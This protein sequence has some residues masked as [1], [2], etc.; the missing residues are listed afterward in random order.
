VIPVAEFRA[1]DSGRGL[2]TAHPAVIAVVLAGGLLL[3]GIIAI[4]IM[5][6]GGTNMMF[7]AG[8]RCPGGQSGT[9]TTTTTQ[10]SPRGKASIPANYLAIY[11]QTGQRYGVPWPILAGIGEVESDHGRSS[12]PGV[13]SGVQRVRRG[14]P[15]ADRDRRGRG[16]HLGRRAGPPRRA[17]R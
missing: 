3:I 13:H 10:V 2:R 16:Q 9:T 12:L 8:G 4:P 14:G 1:R 5:V 17:S 15:D 11:Q 7:A 6:V